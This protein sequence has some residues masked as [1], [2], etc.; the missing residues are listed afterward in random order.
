MSQENTTQSDY[1]YQPRRV[2]RP[3][4]GQ[5][6]ARAVVLVPG[7][8]GDC[9]FEVPDLKY[10][11]VKS[12]YEAAAEILA[13]PTAALIVDLRLVAEDHFGLLDVAHQVNTET[14]AVGPVPPGLTSEE[15][16]GVRLLS[17]TALPAVMAELSGSGPADR[18]VPAEAPAEQPPPEAPAEQRPADLPAG[19]A[20]SKPAATPGEILS[21]EELSALLEDGS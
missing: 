5:A 19:D 21:A 18:D 4:R 12:P 10:V 17:R 6:A 15:L 13:E 16:S 7:E 8:Q 20:V 11:R 1:P 3:Q 14:F 2:E 9:D